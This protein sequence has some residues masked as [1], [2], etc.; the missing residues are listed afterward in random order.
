MRMV[1][2]V[3]FTILIHMEIW[4]IMTKK[5]R[6]LLPI[7]VPMR[8]TSSWTQKST[9]IIHKMIMTRRTMKKSA[10]TV[11]KKIVVLKKRTATRRRMKMLSTRKLEMAK[12]INMVIM[13]MNMK[14][15]R[16]EEIPHIVMEEGH[17]MMEMG[18]ITTVEKATTIAED[19]IV[20][21]KD[22]MTEEEATMMANTVE[23]MDLTA[24]ATMVIDL[25]MAFCGNSAK[26]DDPDAGAVVGVVTLPPTWIIPI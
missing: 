26:S 19:R 23:T 15:E 24:A 17:I 10:V 1:E 20:M 16:T 18:H 3:D 9:L 5:N 21:E 13:M 6:G 22:I 14:I 8:R 12:M 11:M 7:W 25:A 4:M 2:T